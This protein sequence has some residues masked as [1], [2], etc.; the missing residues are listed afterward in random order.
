MPLCCHSPIESPPYC[1]WITTELVKLPLSLSTHHH[2]TTNQMPLWVFAANAPNVYPLSQFAANT[3]PLRLPIHR[4]SSTTWL[5]LCCHSV[6]TMSLRLPMIK[7]ST[8]SLPIQ[9]H[10]TTTVL[11][12]C[13]YNVTWL[14]SYQWVTTQR[15]YCQSTATVQPLGQWIMTQL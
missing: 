4:Q 8:N 14:P 5:P 2:W 9:C 13:K 6:N 12:L 1:H 11:T 3:V 10:L 7:H 15:I